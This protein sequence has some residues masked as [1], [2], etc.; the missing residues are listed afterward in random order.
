MSV[1]DNTGDAKRRLDDAI[2]RGLTKAAIVIQNSAIKRVPVDTGRLRSSIVYRIKPREAIIGTNVK[3]AAFVEFGTGIYAEGGK[4]RKT[5]W[6]YHRGRGKKG[7][8][9]RTRGNKPQPFL[10]PAFAF[11]KDDAMNCIRDEIRR[12]TE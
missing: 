7:R 2:I 5:P 6:V 10:V 12:A 11:S 8:F 4:G 1:I 3:Y 9:V